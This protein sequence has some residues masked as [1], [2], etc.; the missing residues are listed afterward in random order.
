MTT[1]LF[2]LILTTKIFV[3][4]KDLG[5]EATREARFFK[6]L[7]YVKTDQTRIVRV[8]GLRTLC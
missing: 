4:T 8:I 5:D 6:V 7:H 2:I 3:V 1:V